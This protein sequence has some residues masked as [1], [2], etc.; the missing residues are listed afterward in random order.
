MNL[1]LT[2]LA[3]VASVV[4]AAAADLPARSY[5]K[6]PVAAGPTYNWAGLYIGV[7]GGYAWQNDAAAAAVGAFGNMK[8]G[9]GGGTVGYN[10]MVTPNMLLGIEGEAAAAN[11]KQTAVFPPVTWVDTTRAFGSITG[12]VGYVA[13]PVLIYGKGGVDFANNKMAATTAGATVTDAQT[14]VGWTGGGGVEYMFAPSWSL[15]GEY[16]YAQFGNKAYFANTVQSGDL[17]L[18]TVKGGINYHF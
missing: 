17:K 12:R 18:H 8:G 9:F 15:K 10:L 5:S 7:Q 14:H 4:S 2:S 6:A 16:L 1:K 11:I 3:L 13:G